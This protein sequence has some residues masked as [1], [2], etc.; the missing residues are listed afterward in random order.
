M[1]RPTTRLLATLA[2]CGLALAAVP[3]RADDKAVPAPAD[4]LKGPA[5]HDRDVPGVS[6]SFGEAGPEKRKMAEE[7][8]PPRVFRE[9]MQPLLDDDAPAELRLDADKKARFRSMIEGFEGEV[10]EYMKAHRD[11]VQKLRAEAGVKDGPRGER[12]GEKGGDRRPGAGLE[13]ASPE[14][15]EK[16][17]ALMEGAPK[18]EDVYTKIWAEL[19]P[20]QRR[21]VDSRLDEWRAKRSQERQEMYVRNKAGKKAA[22][23]AK[24]EA[25]A[26]GRTPPGAPGDA[27]RMPPPPRRGPNGQ[28]LGANFDHGPDG[29][30]A[31]GGP[32]GPGAGLPP[33]R[34]D[35]LIALFSRLSP[36]QQEQVLRRLENLPGAG[37]DGGRP[38]GPRPDGDRPAPRRRRPG[39]PGAEGGRP[40]MPPPPPGDRPEGQGGP[41]DAMMPPPPPPAPGQGPDDR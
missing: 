36:E 24:A 20:A 33:E 17:R 38:E 25:D 10:R 26:A 7:R 27:P 5:V 37:P 16:F 6:G 2:A 29:P 4:A 41:D 21:A 8:I 18:I 22:G 11:E 1:N 31:P 28:H 9:A 15:R 23:A 13:N 14:A 39:G 32:G 3:A 30:G 40:D 34:R 35:R 12:G 19:T